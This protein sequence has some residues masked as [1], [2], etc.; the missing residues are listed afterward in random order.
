M[1]LPFFRK[2]CFSPHVPPTSIPFL[3]PLIGAVFYC[4]SLAPI[5]HF[6]F[7][8]QITHRSIE[9]AINKWHL[10]ANFKSYFTIL[11]FLDYSAKQLVISF[12][13]Y[14]LSLI[15]VLSLSVVF[16]STSLAISHSPLLAFLS[17]L[18]KCWNAPKVY[19]ELFSLLSLYSVSPHYPT[20][21]L[22]LSPLN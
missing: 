15:F 9:I 14:F 17:L 21:S 4:L 10:N 18:S 6:E 12:L 1:E 3:L 16:L 22:P 13:Q 2:P 8:L 5:F 11:I 20:C 19:L 7:S